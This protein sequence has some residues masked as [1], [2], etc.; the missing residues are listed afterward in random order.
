MKHTSRTITL[1]SVLSVLLFL[2]VFMTLAAC[3]ENANASGKV[4]LKLWYWNRSIDDDLIAA[5]NKQFPNIELRAE[6]ITDYDNKVRTSMAGHYG[7]PD[8]MGINDNIATYFPAE[9]QF[10]DLRTLGADDV[11]S[12]YLEWKW[13]LGVTPD[14]KMIGFPM[15]TG[16]TAL[17]YRADLFEKAGLPSD[18]A[19]VAAQFKT[20]DDYLQAAV[21]YKEATNGKSFMIDNTNTVYNQIL[22]QSVKRYFTTSNQY[23]GNDEHIKQIWNE[24]TKAAQ[25]GVT[26]KV[27]NWTP[28]WN[29]ATNNGQI[30]SFVGASWM[31]QVL[32]EAA[33]DTAGKW[34]ITYAP[35][36]AGNSGGSFLGITK[37]CQHPK[38]AF[39]VIKWLQSPANQ[40]AGYKALQLYPSAI[41]SLDDPALH[42]KEAFY[43]GEDTTT[44]FSDV[45]KRVPLTYHGPD[46]GL[47]GTPFT[48]QLNLVEFQNKNPDQAWN[49]AQQTAQR[50]LLR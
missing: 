26:A 33:P 48:D 42:Q 20:W 45:A 47:V 39:E 3:G 11:K 28:A 49:D 30:A 5:V 2:S 44:I 6:K 16:P 19:A 21:K 10:I 25:D 34:R 12:Q 7:V 18:P 27:Q 13:N 15:D 43:G 8:I 41:S 17:F 1:R 4:Q 14:G 46:E 50:E 38:E 37:Y 9:D 22:A 31:K 24:A 32:Q 23:I 35:G 29:Q 40:V 36:G